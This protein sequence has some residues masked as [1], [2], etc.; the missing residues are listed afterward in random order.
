LKRKSLTSFVSEH[1]P[2]RN[3]SEKNHYEIKLQPLFTDMLLAK[4]IKLLGCIA[5]KCPF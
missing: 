3:E 4:A 5:K 2:Y 1:H